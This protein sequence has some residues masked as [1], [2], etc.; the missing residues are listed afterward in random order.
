VV[1]GLSQEADQE[2]VLLQK[3]E[4]VMARTKS[5]ARNKPIVGI[6]MG[7][8]SDWATMRP[9]AERLDA[10]GIRCDVRVV[11]AHR[12][13][14]DLFEYA[15]EA[16]GKNISLI[17]AG[18]GGAAHLPG[19]AA[20]KTIVPVIGVPVVATPLLGVDALLSV[21]QMP[22]EV[23]VATVGVGAAGAE[24]AAIFAARILAREDYLLRAKLHE[25]RGD[26]VRE[27]PRPSDNTLLGQ[28]PNVMILA[29]EES[30]F[31]VLE[32]AERQFA[33]L[34]IACNRRYV[35]RSSPMESLLRV[36]TEAEEGGIVAY[37]VGS[38]HGIES[39]CMLATITLL[40]VFVV[41]IVSKPVDSIDEFVRPF[42]KITSGVAT[43]AIGRAGAI[44]AALFAA[45]IL[46]APG[47]TLRTALKEKRAE[48][49]RRVR[50][51]TIE[52]HPHSI[53]A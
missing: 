46:S 52:W 25:L 38:R 34:K 30:D 41:P 35:D 42:F 37:I 31:T 51:M 33:E 14:D 10:L 53:K 47:S 36:T 48:Q 49:V 6:I 40:P 9:A 4:G 39:A 43:F 44:N 15:R 24:Q 22:A 11:S 32:N 45:T 23:G 28:A 5:T 1:S 26:L 8:D 17:I 27:V 16:E 19:M 7:S 3:F 20:S 21:M 13:P 18:A 29:E 12:T 50:Q 2:S